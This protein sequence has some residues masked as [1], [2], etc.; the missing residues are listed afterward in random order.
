MRNYGQ[1]IF[2]IRVQSGK[3]ITR[4]NSMYNIICKQCS[5]VLVIFLEKMNVSCAQMAFPDQL[6]PS[7]IL[8]VLCENKSSIKPRLTRLFI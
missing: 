4:P 6:L 8:V 7:F 2:I 3:Q 1:P 5:G